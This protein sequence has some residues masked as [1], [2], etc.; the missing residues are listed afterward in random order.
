MNIHVILIA[1]ALANE[2]G[3]LL[4]V[5]SGPNVT[6]HLFLHSNDSLVENVCVHASDWPNVRYHPYRVN[7]GLSKSVNEGII[8]ALADNADVIIIPND[9]V[10]ME[11]TDFDRLAQ[12][13][14]EH[15]ECGLVFCNGYDR[16]TEQYEDLKF[17][18][19]GINRLALANVGYFDQN[20]PDYFCDCDYRYRCELAGVPIYH[21]DTD[22]I[23]IGSAT[24]DNVPELREQL[25]WTFPAD[26]A[27]FRR[28]WGGDPYHE[29]FDHP[30]NDP[31]LSYLIMEKDRDNPYPAYRRPE[32]ELVRR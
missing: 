17:C 15:P 19:F 1:Y 21:L 4:R 8:N 32:Q 11:W 23:H 22:I 13:C 31:S 20:L 27:Y 28:K 29:T 6:F 26:N 2:L 10:M 30:F 18:V 14:V 3:N 9:D 12:V 16:K 7:R 24:L 5:I 25:Q